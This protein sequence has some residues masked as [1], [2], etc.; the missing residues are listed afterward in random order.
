M[1]R[2]GIL[3]NIPTTW[4]RS[5]VICAVETRA[6]CRSKALLVGLRTSPSS[7]LNSTDNARSDP[8][9][10]RHCPQLVRMSMKISER[11]IYGGR[12]LR[13][14]RTSVGGALI[15]GYLGCP[16]CNSAL[17]QLS[18]R[19]LAVPSKGR[20]PRRCVGCDVIPPPA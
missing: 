5:R 18:R 8:I 6:W 11:V 10:L 16:G 13:R 15:P 3:I 7:H 2:S 14:F 12:R 9:E 20:K 17:F 4:V 19:R 1:T